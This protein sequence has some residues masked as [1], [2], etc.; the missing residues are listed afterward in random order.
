MLQIGRA[1]FDLDCSRARVVCTAETNDR[2]F[3]ESVAKRRPFAKA[4]A[5]YVRTV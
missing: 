2:P 3:S 5:G 4:F 1:G